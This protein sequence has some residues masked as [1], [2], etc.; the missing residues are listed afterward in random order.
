VLIASFRKAE[1][2]A[3]PISGPLADIEFR[4]TPH[5]FIHLPIS[6]LTITIKY[7]IQDKIVSFL[8]TAIFS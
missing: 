5:A 6:L 7:L 2:P 1:Y 3:K 8:T 4:L